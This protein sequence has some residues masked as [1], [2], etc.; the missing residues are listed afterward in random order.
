[1]TAACPALPADQG[2]IRGVLAA[3]DC[4]VQTFSQAGYQALTGPQSIYPTALTALLTIYVAVL[5]YRLM[6]GL[7]GARLA[8]APL[9]GLKIGA[10]LAVSLSWTTF[11][12]LVFD[13]VTKAPLEVARIVGEPAARSGASLAADPLGG[14]QLAYDQMTDDAAA[15]ALQAGPNPQ[16]LKGGDALAA[17]GLWKAATILF[18]STAGVF[19][20]ASVTSGVLSAIGPIFIAMFLFDA[21]RGL[22]TG[23]ARAMIAA[24]LA[25]IACWITTEIL[26]VVMEPWLVNLAQE[27]AAGAMNP[28]T[29]NA[30]VAVVVVFAIAQAGLIISGG[31]I[32]GGLELRPGARREGARRRAERDQ[33][34]AQSAPSRAAALAQR[35]HATQSIQADTPRLTLTVD[36]RT[37]VARPESEMRSADGARLGASHRRNDPGRLARR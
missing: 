30:V 23:W 16:V 21:T 9:I 18:M 8:D 15:F 7:G 10:L 37:A 25:P 13:V 35:L 26:L 4:N 12:T 33:M 28:S 11:Q 22:F 6:F 31:V 24:A 20:L 36:R 1:M 5:G 2:L 3:V 29:A 17:D 27:R 34:A 32:A 14:L 19:A